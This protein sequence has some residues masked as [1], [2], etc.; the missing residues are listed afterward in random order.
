[1]KSGWGRRGE[2]A[3]GRHQFTQSYFSK[4]LFLHQA[5]SVTAQTGGVP[6]SRSLLSGGETNI[7]IKQ[8]SPGRRAFQTWHWR[9]AMPASQLSG[10]AGNPAPQPVDFIPEVLGCQEP[11]PQ[12]APPG[13]CHLIGACCGAG[14][15]QVFTAQP[16]SPEAT[17]SSRKMV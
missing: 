11:Q 4:Q 12:G 17:S 16:W 10:P 14:E 6:A 5:W 3:A 8:T 9:A 15:V 13:A 2:T 1:M 7:H